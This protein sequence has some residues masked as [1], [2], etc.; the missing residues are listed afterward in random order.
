MSP[1]PARGRLFTLLTLTLVYA[2]NHFDRQVLLILQGPIKAEF[3]LSDGDLGLLTGLAF[4]LFYST[5]GIPAALWADRGV[6]KNIIA[7]AL[8]IWSAMT[9]LSGLAQNYVQLA[10]ARMGV[11]VGEAGGTPPATSMIADLYGPKERATAMGVYTL[12]IGIG[13]MAGFPFGD[14]IVSKFGWRVAFFAAGVPGL[15]LAV[16]VFLAVREP[17]RGAA[18]QRAVAAKAPGMMES[19]RFFL[20]QP[21]FVWL[22]VGCTLICISANAWLAW[23]PEL[24]SRQFEYAPGER[25]LALG[26]LIGGLGC[27]GAILIGLLCDRLSRRSL[28]WRPLTILACGALALPFAWLTLQADTKWGF[29]LPYA[30]PSFIGLIYASLAYTAAQE[31]VGVRMRA[32]AAAFTLL[33]L[34]LLGIGLGPTLA[35]WLS[36]W[37]AARQSENSLRDALSVTLLLNALSLPAL[38]LSARTYRR[39]VARA[40]ALSDAGMA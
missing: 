26:T 32:F 9:A 21:A 1:A 38:A 10:L 31:L 20:S 11:A 30:V 39:D 24:L 12:G 4:A 14:L 3:Q 40:N 33:C 22:L 25:G 35:G 23:V 34:T 8:A 36:D 27:A 2:F 19:L 7:G 6:R 29:Y 18:D 17:K 5:L 37:F 15:L 13:I 16:F 28:A